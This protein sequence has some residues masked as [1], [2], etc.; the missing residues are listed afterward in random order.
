MDGVMLSPNGINT[1]ELE[2]NQWT[3]RLSVDEDAAHVGGL[4]LYGKGFGNY[5]QDI[6]FRT[7]YK[8]Q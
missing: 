7:Y 2:R 1:I 8:Q 4:T 5:N 6:V 3:L